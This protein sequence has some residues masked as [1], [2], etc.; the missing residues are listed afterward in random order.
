LGGVTGPRFRGPD[1]A[2]HPKLEDRPIPDADRPVGRSWPLLPPG[3]QGH[4]AEQEHQ[5]Q[6]GS[7]G[8]HGKRERFRA[9]VPGQA[10]LVGGGRSRCPGGVPSFGR[11]VDGFRR[12]ANGASRGL[13]TPVAFTL[14]VLVVLAWAVTGPLFHFSDSWQLVINTGTTVVT[15]LMVF[16][17]QA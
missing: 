12:F 17:I 11:M 6:G 13:G 1:A 16:L 8:L 3:A 7:T 15:F 4:P 14:A 10:S 2:R 9:A 5:R